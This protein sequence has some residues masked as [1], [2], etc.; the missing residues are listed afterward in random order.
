MSS[1][2]VC[3]W[4]A[5]AAL[6]VVCTGLSQSALAADGKKLAPGRRGQIR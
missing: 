3:R 4:F 2:N 6:C 1:A 5:F